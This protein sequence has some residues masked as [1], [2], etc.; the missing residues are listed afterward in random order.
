MTFKGFTDSK[1]LLDQ[2][3]KFKLLEGEK[4]R[5]MLPKSWK[6]SFNTGIIWYHFTCK[7]ETL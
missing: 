2:S 4:V 1:R 7:H 6:K 3:Q 5:V